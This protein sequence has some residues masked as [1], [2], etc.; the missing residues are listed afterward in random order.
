MLSM[1]NIGFLDMCKY[2]YFNTNE[3]G[4][5][6]VAEVQKLFFYATNRELKYVNSEFICIFYDV[7]TK[8]PCKYF[9][10]DIFLK[11]IDKFDELISNCTIEISDDMLECYFLGLNTY[12]QI[13]EVINDFSKLNFSSEIKNRQY[14]IP[15]YTSLAEGCLA[16]L[17]R[18]FAKLINQTV[19][20]DYS[21]ITNLNTL[22]EMLIS[23]GWDFVTGDLNISIRNAINHGKV[24]FQE[25]G[26]KIKFLYSSNRQIQS[27]ELADY[28]FENLINSIYDLVSSLV[29]SISYFLN[30]YHHIIQINLKDENY[31]SYQYLSMI[32]SKPSV[33]FKCIYGLS[34]NR[35][36][37]MDIVVENYDRGFLSQLSFILL[38]IVYSYHCNFG[39]YLLGISGERLQGGWFILNNDQ[40]NGILERRYELSDVYRTAIKDRNVMIWEPSTEQID[41]QEIK[42]FRFPNYIC[43]EY[44]I[45]NVADASLPERKRLRCDLFIGEVKA[46]EKIVEIINQ[47][48]G[49]VKSLKNVDSPTLHHKNGTMEADSIYMHVY[50]LDGRKNKEI[51]PNNSNFV[52]YVDYN[53]NGETTLVNGGLPKFIW[54]K[55]YH[56]KKGDSIISWREQEYCDNTKKKIGVNELCPCGSGKKFKKCCKGKGIFD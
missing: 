24:I 18:F 54:E 33:R 23:N 8:V 41:L 27:I 10:K 21:N 44:I 29:L 11:T 28:D 49:W 55:L 22:C 13:T 43:E 25:N 40:I 12:E 53:V 48:L 52:C 50:R 5:C 20:K 4:D 9:D 30:K 46:K 7:L 17:Y 26:K 35:Q 32:L 42:Y 6:K 2:K 3:F 56:E 37:N 45:S 47:A 36:L 15:T 51:M 39:K 1:F 14:R 16:N 38:S 19:S 34:E 31:L